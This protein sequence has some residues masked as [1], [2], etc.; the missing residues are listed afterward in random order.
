ME[1]GILVKE[2]VGYFLTLGAVRQW[3]ISRLF[4]EAIWGC[5][6]VGI[7]PIHGWGTLGR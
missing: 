4:A 6:T 5:E 7:F 1:G 3:D 2:T